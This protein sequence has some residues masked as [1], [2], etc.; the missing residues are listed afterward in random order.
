MRGR[1]QHPGLWCERP[2]EDARL[3]ARCDG[4]AGREGCDGSFEGFQLSQTRCR[5]SV[6]RLS[7]H[8]P[9]QARQNLTRLRPGDR[10]TLGQRPVCPSPLR[11]HCEHSKSTARAGPEGI[12][13]SGMGSAENTQSIHHNPSDSPI[14]HNLSEPFTVV[15]LGNA[16]TAMNPVPASSFPTLPL[17]GHHPRAISSREQPRQGVL[18]DCE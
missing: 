3:S 12:V 16:V 2:S 11:I 1:V 5:R 13:P 14:H 4:W 8:C 6:G 9:G 17:I 7:G 10:C 15:T 18:R